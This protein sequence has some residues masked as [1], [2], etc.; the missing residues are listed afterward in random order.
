MVAGLQQ[1]LT[2][3]WVIMATLPANQDNLMNEVI[4]L[5][6]WLVVLMTLKEDMLVKV[7]A[8]QAELRGLRNGMDLEWMKG[9]VANLQTKLANTNAWLA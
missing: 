3:L 9:V 5:W 4:M 2:N 7:P 6:R 8:L 1:E